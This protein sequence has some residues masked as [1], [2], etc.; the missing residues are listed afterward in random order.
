MKLRVH[1]TNHQLSQYIDDKTLV[2]LQKGEK[3]DVITTIIDARYPYEFRG[4]HIKG[5][6]NLY[7][8]DMCLDYF[9]G[10]QGQAQ[11]LLNAI[12]EKENFSS[13]GTF[14]L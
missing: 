10:A 11:G 6:V 5:A 9:Y 14:V 3:S 12:G 7:T 13:N 1:S 8:K 2:S 4:G